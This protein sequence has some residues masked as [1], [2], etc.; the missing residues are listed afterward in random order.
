MSQ[1]ELRFHRLSRTAL[2]S[3]E[4]ANLKFDSIQYPLAKSRYGCSRDTPIRCGFQL[5]RRLFEPSEGMPLPI[6]ASD[7][8][9]KLDVRAS[10]VDRWISRFSPNK[11]GFPAVVCYGERLPK[12]FVLAVGVVPVSARRTHATVDLFRR[13][14]RLG[15]MRPQLYPALEEL[16]PDRRKAD[17]LL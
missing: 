9:S 5:R 12:P 3:S 13:C 4:P 2:F 8:T 11:N 15:V 17:V 1:S 7:G 14:C 6:G 16:W 10:V